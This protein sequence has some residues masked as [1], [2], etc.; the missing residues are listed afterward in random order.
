MY[1]CNINIQHPKEVIN[2][3]KCDVWFVSSVLCLHHISDFWQHH[4]IT[5]LRWFYD[6]A[7]F[8]CKAC[9]LQLLV[10]LRQENLMIYVCYFSDPSL[11]LG[12]TPD[13]GLQLLFSAQVRTHGDWGLQLPGHWLCLQCYPGIYSILYYCVSRKNSFIWLIWC[14]ILDEILNYLISSKWDH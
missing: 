1:Q 3:R 10:S 7:D 14:G 11:E 12:P 2:A 9:R 8:C 13:P 5:G 4:P 6:I